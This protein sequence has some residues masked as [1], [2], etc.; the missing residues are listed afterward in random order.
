MILDKNG[1]PVPVVRRQIGFTGS[2]LPVDEKDT[3]NMTPAKGELEGPWRGSW[4]RQWKEPG[5]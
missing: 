1:N 2:V 4:P 3:I 5:E